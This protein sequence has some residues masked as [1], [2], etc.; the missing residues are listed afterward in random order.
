M[1]KTVDEFWQ[2]VDDIVGKTIS[3]PNSSL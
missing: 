3:G 2:E 1:D